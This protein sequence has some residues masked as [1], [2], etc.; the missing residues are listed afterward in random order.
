M[1][2]C[3][4]L[5]PQSNHSDNDLHL[6]FNVAYNESELSGG[7]YKI[8]TKAIMRC[9]FGQ[10]VIHPSTDAAQQNN[11]DTVVVCQSNGTWRGFVP[12]CG[13]F[14]ANFFPREKNNC[15]IGHHSFSVCV[16]FR[17]ASQRF[18]FVATCHHCGL[19]GFD[20]DIRSG[21]RPSLRIEVKNWKLNEI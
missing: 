13:K 11:N 5:I 12:L 2:T 20:S 14:F 10:R 18:G 19:C 7:R 17:S 1:A 21:R 15:K 6:R 3:R 16:H 8:G 9:N 4:S